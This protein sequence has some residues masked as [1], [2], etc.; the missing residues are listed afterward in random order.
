VL[1]LTWT[2][3][4]P[5]QNPTS[6]PAP[7]GAPGTT[8]TSGGIDHERSIEEIANFLCR[9]PS[10][11]RQRIEEIAEADAIGDPSLLCD[12]LTYRD[13]IAL[14]T[15]RDARFSSRL[16]R[17]SCSAVEGCAPPGSVTREDF[18]TPEFTLQVEALVRGI[19]AIAGRSSWASR[20]REVTRTEKAAS[21]L[22]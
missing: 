7:P 12:G 8:R 5:L 22:G 1:A 15:Y 6:T 9:T 14:E 17:S 10:E 16:S 20:A 18:L 19:Y 13:R 4:I 3:L 2:A 11:V 21:A